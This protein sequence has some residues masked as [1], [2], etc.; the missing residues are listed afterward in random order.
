VYLNSLGNSFHYDDSHAIVGNPH[1]RSLAELPRVLV[2]PRT[3][4]REPQMAMYRPLLVA[5]YSLNYALGGLDPIGFRLVNLGLH[6]ACA[7]LLFRLLAVVFGAWTRAWWGAALFA[8]HPVQSQVVN[9]ISSRSESLA[10]A[11]VLVALVVLWTPRSR[12]VVAVSAYAASLLAKSSAVALLPLLG[13]TRWLPAPL[14]QSWRRQA[15]FWLATTAYLVLTIANRFLTRSLAQDVRP[16]G[17]QLLT[18]A[19]ALVYYLWLAVVPVHLSVEHALEPSLPQWD[20]PVLASLVLLLS[21]AVLVWRLRRRAGWI[22][23]GAAWMAAG[24]GLTVVVPLN[25]I[26]NEHRLYLALGGWVVLV[27]G[28]LR[29]GPATRRWLWLGAVGLL[30]LGLLTWQR[31]AV[32]RD[33][34]SLWQDAAAR[35]PRLFRAQSNLGLALYEAGQPA[36]AA[37]VLERALRLNPGYAKAWNNL[38]LAYEDLGRPADA[39][40]AYRHALTT[41]PE[42]AG[43]WA[44]LG[45]LQLAGGELSAAR[46]AL[47]KAVA[48][49]PWA[50][51]PH[52]TLGL[53]EQREASPDAAVAQYRQALAVDPRSAEAS[54]NLGLALQELG[55]TQAAL[56]AL[57]QAVA[58]RPHDEDARLNLEA[59]QS[60]AAGVPAIDVYAR[61]TRQ[62]PHRP[63]LWEALASARR[64]QDDP[65]GAA[66]A[67]AQ[68][69]RL[70]P[71]RADRFLRW[72]QVLAAG[73]DQA[74]A[75]AAY[76][77]GLEG[78]PASAELLRALATSL[79]ALGELDQAAAACRRLLVVA[80][81]DPR[82]RQNLQQLEAAQG[83]RSRPR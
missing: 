9:Y 6:A 1:I 67:L 62:Y 4:S 26:V 66:A 31:N 39:L 53:L 19:K 49:D 38:G 17:E 48:L 75:A 58:L 2:D 73:G 45:R 33:E 71:R 12:P 21:I 46:Q 76:A 82:A 10:A 30:C 64:R 57:Q 63:E 59:A 47:Q 72:G 20:W 32:W 78:T 34:L 13:A 69:A 15:W 61:L 77:A 65:A 7:L 37:A 44:N 24:L 81:D 8:V 16:Y 35:A 68:A 51:E 70:D 18:Q 60:R 40:A 14:R 3:F 83:G 80:P 42:L 55:Q 41:D 56:A 23:L 79:A 29:G 27:V 43:A 50:P 52:V 28:G 5:T 25:V 22:W 36:A 74:G 54:N 11:G